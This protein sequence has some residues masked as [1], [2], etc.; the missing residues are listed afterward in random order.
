MAFHAGAALCLAPRRELLPGLEL[1]ELLRR[2]RITTVT[3][4]PSVLAALPEAAL[5]DLRTIVVAGEACSVELARRW[6]AGRRLINAY[7]PTE[8]TVCATAGLYDGGGDRL[9]VG[10]P[11]QNV[12]A[13][14][15]DPEGQLSPAGVPG[16]LLVGG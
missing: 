8:A 15:F 6:S 10:R 3:L 4:P 16:E 5:P 7:G 11:I 14:V 1:I 13:Y 2:E 12:E 9:P